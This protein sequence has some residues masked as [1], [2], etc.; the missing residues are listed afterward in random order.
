MTLKKSVFPLI[1]LMRENNKSMSHQKVSWPM[2]FTQYLLRNTSDLQTPCEQV[3]QRNVLGN[4]GWHLSTYNQG[5][6]NIFITL[7]IIMQEYHKH[8]DVL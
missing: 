3:Q 2:Q 8:V 4:V 7:T 1:M 6:K 5:G